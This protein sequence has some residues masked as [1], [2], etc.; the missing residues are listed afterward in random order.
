LDLV[1]VNIDAKLGGWQKSKDYLRIDGANNAS[2]RGDFIE[3]F[4]DTDITNNVK[5]F[6]L[7]SKA[8]GVGINLVRA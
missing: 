8:G 6:L 1:V 5:A 4:N 3:Q 7:S 2:E